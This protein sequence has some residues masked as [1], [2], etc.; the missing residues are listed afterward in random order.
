MPAPRW[1]KA[2]WQS[3]H[4][5]GRCLLALVQWLSWILLVVIAGVQ[6]FLLTKHELDVPQF[7]L[8]E[9]EKR[10]ADAGLHA[11]FGKFTFD[12]TGRLLVRDAQLSL[13]SSDATVI[14]AQSISM[15]VDPIALWL[16][17]IDP[18]EIQFS[19]I[20]LMIPAVISPTGEA[21]PIVAGLDARVR[22][23]ESPR[24]LE[25]ANLTAQIGP[26]SV[27]A[28][29][30]VLIPEPQNA[31]PS[32]PLDQ[33]LRSFSQNYLQRCRQF[34]DVLTKLPP[35]HGAKLDIHFTPHPTLG[36]EASVNVRAAQVSVTP[37]VED[38]GIV[39]IH[40][41]AL[42][43]ELSPGGEK[44]A[45]TLALQIGQIE[46]PDRAR[47]HDLWLHLATD[48]DPTILSV[49]P[50]RLTLASRRV[51]AQGINFDSAR[52][53]A[54]LVGAP[55]I[56]AH[57]TLRVGGGEWSFATDVDATNGAGRVTLA[58][59]V[60]DQTLQLAADKIGFD[61]PSILSW[62]QRPALTAE[63]MLGPGGKPLSA[64]ADLSTGPVVARWVPLDATS[65][66]VTWENHQLRA[67]KIHLRRGNSRAFGSYEMNTA[68]TR[69]R[70]LLN[71]Q[72]VPG[73]INGWFRD[74]WPQ[75]FAMFDFQAGPPRASVEVSGRWKAKLETQIFISADAD[76]VTV[77]DI[78]M[79]RMRTRL[80]VRPGWVDVL[81]FISER[82]VGTVQGRFARQWH[83]PDS[84]RWTRLEIHAGGR[85]DLSPVPKLL[86][87]SGETLI[88]PF[89]FTGPMELRL[90]GA[91]S[92]EDW[93]RPTTQNFSFSGQTDDAWRYK[94]FPLRGV[95]FEGRQNNDQISIDEFT[96]GFGAGELKGKILLT[97]SGESKNIGFDVNLENA[98]LGRTIQDVVEWSAARKGET[99][100]APTDFQKQMAAG[101]L[102]LSL[103]AEGPADDPFDLEGTGS[104]AVYHP[105]L[106]NL[107]LLG[108]LSALLKTTLLNFSTL[109]LSHANANFT[110]AGPRVTFPELKISGDRG[111]LDASGTYLLD[112]KELNFTSRVRP[113]EGGEGLLDA[114]FT[115]F[116]SVLE[117]KLDGQLSKPR[118]TFVYGP[119]NI[120]RN[121]TGENNRPNSETRNTRQNPNTPPIETRDRN[122]EIPPEPPK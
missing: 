31:G 12:P 79:Q 107:N 67:D 55:V 33:L 27:S 14:R 99:A 2:C 21:E 39:H 56:Q 37:P 22:R 65:A 7:V 54:S 104:A 95:V 28:F 122:G 17:E 97:G 8:R 59:E 16:H 19:G 69:F 66:H 101:E 63:L 11:R 114:V 38:G 64:A 110:L 116:S 111:A 121:I 90:D 44:R 81:N 48:W 70:F 88:E 45:E 92:R 49:T 53:H 80:F 93:G 105:D 13:L 89:A 1:L 102:T 20:D 120:L 25:I 103:S 87:D 76:D 26:F 117:V 73:D 6:I 41:I 118:W 106:A 51:S 75:L 36:A 52:I 43:G 9:A 91:I 29:G 61:V 23:G 100:A 18:S 74:W 32:V 34:S 62:S 94:N 15:R 96:T 60:G 30:R 85:S 4:F 108:P 5:C 50:T 78:P 112:T 57:G 10:L 58:G 83:L 119:T 35:I 84:R 82:E 71:G 47:A 98:S 109:Q 3:S 72:L 24:L 68:D 46:W 86:R 77:K 115:P 40:D 42:S 113:F